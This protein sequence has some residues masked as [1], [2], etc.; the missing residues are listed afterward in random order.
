MYEMIFLKGLTYLQMHGYSRIKR[1]NFRSDSVMSS[2]DY[3]EFSLDFETRQKKATEFFPKNVI[4]FNSFIYWYGALVY[5][6]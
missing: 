4:T 1:C 6:I 5:K 2:G 3:N